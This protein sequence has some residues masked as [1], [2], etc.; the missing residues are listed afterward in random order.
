MAL[1]GRPRQTGD[2]DIWLRATPDNAERLMR[3]LDDFGFGQLGL[4][5][6]HF[7]ASER[8][9]QLGDPP[10][11]IDLLTSIDGVDFDT[12]WTTRETVR[13]DGVDLPFIGL[14]A[15]KANKRASGRPRDIDDLAQLP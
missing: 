4:S 10:F 2:L 13:H 12:A 15:L 14:D 8:V 6:D 9:V 7:V 5:A 1:H 3:A 11:R